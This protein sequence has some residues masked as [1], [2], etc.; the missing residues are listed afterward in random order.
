MPKEAFETYISK[1]LHKIEE[2]RVA[3]CPRIPGDPSKVLD[4]FL[5]WKNP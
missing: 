5:T 3:T 2:S 4:F 1:K